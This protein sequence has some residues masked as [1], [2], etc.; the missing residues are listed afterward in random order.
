MEKVQVDQTAGL[1]AVNV[2]V[3]GNELHHSMAYNAK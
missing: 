1:L 3:F 2:F